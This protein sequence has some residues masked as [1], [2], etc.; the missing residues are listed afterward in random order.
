MWCDPEDS[1]TLL[2]L[3]AEKT[4]AQKAQELLDIAQQS[5]IFSNLGSSLGN[6]FGGGQ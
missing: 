2:G 4:A 5:G 1:R 3:P 6:L